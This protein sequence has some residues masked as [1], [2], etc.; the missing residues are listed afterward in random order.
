MAKPLTDAEKA[1]FLDSLRRVPVVIVACESIGRARATMQY[2]RDHDEAFKAAWDAAIQ[3]GR[4]LLETEAIRRAY[5]GVEEPVFYQGNQV[6]TTR[7][8][9][10]RLLEFLL[11]GAF[12]EK[13]GRQPDAPKT[14]GEIGQGMTNNELARRI[15]HLLPEV[16]QEYRKATLVSST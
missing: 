13:Y 15:A 1:A 9:S 4:E 10:D 2:A 5:E 12:R 14:A 16:A 8:Y 7:K 11:V 3:D 6:G